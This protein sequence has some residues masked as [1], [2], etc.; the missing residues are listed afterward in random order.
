VRR[1]APARGY[2]PGLRWCVVTA[3]ASFIA[4]ASLCGALTANSTPLARYPNAAGVSRMTLAKVAG[5]F[6]TCAPYTVTLDANG[7]AEYTGGSIGPARVVPR[8][9][10][11]CA[12]DPKWTFMTLA[13][14]LGE[15]GFFA[16]R[17]P[18][19]IIMDAQ[20]TTVTVERFG[21]TFTTTTYLGDDPDLRVTQGVLAFEAIAAG[22]FGWG[23]RLVGA[24]SE[25][26]RRP[27]TCSGK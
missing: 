27:T 7:T 4:L 26:R 19:R 13:Q 22:L 1:G 3:A 25:I 16:D 15:D 23:P 12:L 18:P 17:P 11:F 2:E 24:E 6:G 5:C 20:V 8:H 9:M 14:I 21:R 10:K